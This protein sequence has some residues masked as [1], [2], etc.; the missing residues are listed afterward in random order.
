MNLLQRLEHWGDRHHPQWLDILRIALGGFLCYKGMEFLNSMSEMLSL[1]SGN[2][3]FSSFTLTLLAH[4]IV[5][6]HVGGGVLIILGVLTRLACVVQI[7]VLLGAIIFIN[8]SQGLWSP[9]S[10]LWI[11]IFVLLLL[12]Y[13][14]VIGNGP[15]SLASYLDRENKK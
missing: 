9:F 4:Y 11:S 6:A 3:S 10:E 14:L 5:F 1:M 2:L 8:A 13:F 15:W 7:P 12:I